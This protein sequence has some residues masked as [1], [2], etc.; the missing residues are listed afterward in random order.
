[1]AGYPVRRILDN[2]F[3]LKEYDAERAGETPGSL[4][5]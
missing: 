1:M 3:L 5:Q 2:Y 4:I